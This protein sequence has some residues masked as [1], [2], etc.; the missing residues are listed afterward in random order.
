MIGSLFLLF[1][2]F[3]LAA[4]LIIAPLKVSYSTL[5][6]DCYRHKTLLA[7]SAALFSSIETFKEYALSN[8]RDDEGYSIELEKVAELFASNINELSATQVSLAL[9][10]LGNS[11]SLDNW[12]VCCAS[13]EAKLLSQLYYHVDEGMY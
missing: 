13:L 3:P 4:P 10:L 2:C 9:K 7:S 6:K 11:I 5:Q 1:L 8:R 12:V